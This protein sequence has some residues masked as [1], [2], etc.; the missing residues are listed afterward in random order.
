MVDGIGPVRGIVV[1]D[2]PA[3]PDLGTLALQ[4]AVASVG[5]GRAPG[6]HGLDEVDPYDSYA[7]VKSIGGDDREEASNDGV[8]DT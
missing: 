4:I 3:S 2:H 7:V 6:I 5:V 1:V 8:G